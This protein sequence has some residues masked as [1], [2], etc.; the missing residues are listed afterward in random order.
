VAEPTTWQALS[1]MLLVERSKF[2]L[3]ELLGPTPAVIEELQDEHADS[4]L[5]FGGA[6]VVH[7]VVTGAG[8][9]SNASTSIFLLRCGENTSVCLKIATPNRED[10]DR[11]APRKRI[12]T[13]VQCD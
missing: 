6:M 5:Q 11:R 9:R 8:D 1:A 12:P 7:V 10:V 2:G 13:I 3:N 4:G